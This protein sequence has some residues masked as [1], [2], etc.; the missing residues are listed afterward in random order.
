V[1]SRG[2]AVAFVATA[3]GARAR[4]FYEGVLGLRVIEDAPFALVLDA[5]GTKIRV[6]KVDKVIRVP[7]TA[8]GWEVSDI[9]QTVRALA[10]RGVVFSRYPGMQ[11]DELGIWMAPSGARVA[12]FEDPDGN[13]LSLTG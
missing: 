8:L 2:K 6:Q 3:N 10:E 11:Q 9:V 4:A 5:M 12:W 1:L 13:V 7:Y